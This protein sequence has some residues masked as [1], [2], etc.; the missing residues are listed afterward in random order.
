[1]AFAPPPFAPFGFS[2]EMERV[3]AFDNRPMLS[4]FVNMI[5]TSL[6]LLFPAI[7][8]PQTA[9]KMQAEI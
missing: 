2:A 1:M 7:I 3:F 4:R 6:F 9:A 8:L 5:V